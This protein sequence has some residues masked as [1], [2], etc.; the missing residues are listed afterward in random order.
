MFRRLETHGLPGGPPSER[1]LFWDFRAEPDSEAAVSPGDEPPLRW[2]L[3]LQSWASGRWRRP[4]QVDWLAQSGHPVPTPGESVVLSL[5]ELVSITTAL[6]PVSVVSWEAMDTRDAAVAA[7]NLGQA[8]DMLAAVEKLA[9]VAPDWVD[10]RLLKL[11]V[12]VGQL[13]DAEG[14]Q[15]AYDELP[16]GVLD[17]AAARRVRQSIALLR[18]D[19][20]AYAAEVSSVLESGERAWWN[21]EILGLAYWAAQ[22]LEDALATFEQ[23]MAE[24]DNRLDLALRR[25]EV[26]A[27]MGRDED[28]LTAL[29]ALVAES[30]P[31]PKAWALRG[32]LRRESDPEA[33][34][35]DYSIALAKDPSEAVARVGRGLQRWHAGDLEGARGDLEPYR[36]CGWAAA[37]Q[38][39]V[40]FCAAAGLDAGVH[41]SELPTSHDG[42]DD[43]HTHTHT[44]THGH[45]HGHGHDR[46]GG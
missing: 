25:T 40:D 1:L 45:G 37:W 13:R 29:D 22:R 5:S 26:L 34:A 20:D 38:T 36:Y 14:A 27:A 4:E 6:A 41:P 28:A 3:S 9:Q 10:T 23:G 19:W 24:H 35:A 2:T 8:A 39:W 31:A 44:H 17:D 33:A 11:E 21:F 42:H 18:D 12:L 32:W 46:C 43:G 16:E 30:D 7:L 15:K